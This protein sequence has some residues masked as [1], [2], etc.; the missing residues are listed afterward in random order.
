MTA[1]SLAPTLA[2]LLLVTAACDATDER[3]S[4]G[5]ATS[6]IVHGTDS[7]ATQDAVVLVEHYDAIQIGGAA[8]GCSGTLLTPRLVLTARHCVAD[9]DETAACDSA[10]NPTAGG[11]VHGDHLASK[12]Y[13]FTGTQRPDFLTGLDMGA[14]GVEIIDD[15]AMTLCN[16]DI[17]L[18]L[19]DRALPNAKIAPVRLDDGPHADELVTVVG[20][21]V[22]DKSPD[23]A[24]RQQRAGVMVVA[25]G[26]APS[27]GPAEFELGESGCAGD[28]GGPALAASGAVLGVLSRGGN[29][30]G[31][32]PG[33]P[34]NCIGAKNVFTK[35][36][37]FKDLILAAY[38]KAGQDPWNEGAPDPRTLPPKP[39]AQEK[40]SGCAMAARPASRGPAASVLAL[41]AL[42]AVFAA[43]VMR[44]RPRC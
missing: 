22:S 11:G 42:L 40:R 7:D 41:L 27:I 10:G 17:A 26:P 14:R 12:L 21:G 32:T 38:A 15:A 43:C 1:R 34:A 28:S 31:A 13:A 39:P 36:S 23:P 29:G 30:S 4:T 44:R 9:T 35:A 37:S 6:A 33:D 16:H 2:A 5:T 19:L 20:W 8:A 25:V 18:I 3:E 24:T